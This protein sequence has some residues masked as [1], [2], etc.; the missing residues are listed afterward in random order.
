MACNSDF[1]DRED[2]CCWFHER[3][4]TDRE[5]LSGSNLSIDLEYCF[6]GLE[7]TQLAGADDGFGA[8][9][10]LQFVEN[11][12]VM[13]LDRAERQIQPLADFC[14]G[15]SLGDEAQDFEFAVGERFDKFGNLDLRFW[16]GQ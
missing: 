14:V 1:V 8:V 16:I 7:Q 3:K 9:L 5:V 10:D 6:G 11:P 2:V 15:K 13:S 4:Y 12:Q